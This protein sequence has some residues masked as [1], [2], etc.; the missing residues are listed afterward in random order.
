VSAY[1]GTIVTISHD[2]Y[3]LDKVA[4]QILSL[5]GAGHAE[6]YEGDYTEYHDGSLIERRENF[7]K[8]STVD[9]LVETVTPVERIEPS[10]KHEEVKTPRGKKS[11]VAAP[12]KPAVKVIKKKQ[13]DVRTSELI[14]SEIA[15]AEKRLEEISEQMALP[16]VARDPQQTDQA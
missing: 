8:S 13:F 2:R 15:V 10:A 9:N 11:K 12:A 5:D 4:T 3:F 7:P 1:E 14:E 6:H 16:E